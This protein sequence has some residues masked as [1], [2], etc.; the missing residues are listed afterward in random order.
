MIG[1]F[2][3]ELL[4]TRTCF[5]VTLLKT[6]QRKKV[7]IKQAIV[8]VLFYLSKIE[9]NIITALSSQPNDNFAEKVL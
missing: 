1:A 3:K 2:V 5:G 7:N 8:L 9:K 4:I 6:T